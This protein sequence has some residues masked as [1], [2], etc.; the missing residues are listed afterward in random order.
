M[1][2]RTLA[3]ARVGERAIVSAVVAP[4]ARID[5]LAAIGI[6]PG[7]ELRV[8]QRRPVFVV[9]HDETVLALE[10]DL[11]RAIAIVEAK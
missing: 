4:P 5:K 2:W 8:H 7:V 1:T 6:V 9:E 10:Q 3:E 11:A